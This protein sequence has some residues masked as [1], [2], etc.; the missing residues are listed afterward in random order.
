M[1]AGSGS[2]GDAPGSG[3]VLGFVAAV[4][5]ALGCF[6]GAVA[7]LSSLGRPHDVATGVIVAGALGLGLGAVGLGLLALRAGRRLGGAPPRTRTEVR[8]QPTRVSPRTS[9]IVG[10]VV[11][12]AAVAS[13]AALAVSLHARSARSSAVQDHGVAREAVVT[14]VQPVHHDTR[15]DSWVSYDYGAT[16]ASPVGGTTETLV[17]DPTED[18]QRLVPGDQVDVLVDP[19]DPGYAELP[20][21][22]VQSS[23]WYVGPL[24]LTLVLIGLVALIASRSLRRRRPAAGASRRSSPPT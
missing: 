1:A 22:P 10:T 7:A 12:V 18:S 14:S 5:G 2:P 16:L 19:Q 8:P 15:Y 9:R 13:I 11:L 4:L 24:V 6:I 20:G 17:H 21:R 23:R 3:G